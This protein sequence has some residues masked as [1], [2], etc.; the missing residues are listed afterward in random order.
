MGFVR[1][2]RKSNT[3][4]ALLQFKYFQG[5]KLNFDYHHMS[6]ILEILKNHYSEGH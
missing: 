6:N 1:F 4:D 3:V 5:L 2:E